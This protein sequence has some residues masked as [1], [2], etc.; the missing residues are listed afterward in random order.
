MEIVFKNGDSERFYRQVES[1]K[2]GLRPGTGWSAE[3][4][5]IVRQKGIWFRPLNGA[6]L[7]APEVPTENEVLHNSED[8]LIIVRGRGDS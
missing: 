4:C 3:R 1:L 8:R 7:I 2:N 5:P 6:G